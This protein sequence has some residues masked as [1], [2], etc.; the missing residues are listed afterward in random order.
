MHKYFDGKKLDVL[1]GHTFFDSVKIKRVM[2][3]R[4][5]FLTLL[6]DPYEV[7]RTGYFHGKGY[8]QFDPNVYLTSDALLTNVQQTISRIGGLPPKKGKKLN[9]EQ[10]CERAKTQLNLF[11]L[12]IE[13]KSFSKS[14]ELL[15]NEIRNIF[16]RKVAFF[17]RAIVQRAN[18]ISARFNYSQFDAAVQKSTLT[19]FN[20]N[21][22]VRCLKDLIQQSRLKEEDDGGAR[23]VRDGAYLRTS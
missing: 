3:G 9:P 1:Y 22:Y 2:K 20:Q 10:L 7:S 21:I 13:T 19:K 11:D 6:R 16:P 17:E 23:G 15:V 18:V 14:P 5:Y 8:Q 12:V 4:P